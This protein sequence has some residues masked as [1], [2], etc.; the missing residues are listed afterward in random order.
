MYVCYIYTHL[1]TR[2]SVQVYVTMHGVTGKYIM[3][4]AAN[5]KGSAGSTLTKHL[6]P[7]IKIYRLLPLP[8]TSGT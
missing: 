8:P 6:L 4:N 7:L 2:P 1:C 3:R 5:S